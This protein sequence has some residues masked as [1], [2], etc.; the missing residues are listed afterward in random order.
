MTVDA[1]G[2]TATG[3]G[4]R[5]GVWR[6]GGEFMYQYACQCGRGTGPLRDTLF[7]LTDSPTPKWG[8]PIAQTASTAGGPSKAFAPKCIGASPG[9][10]PAPNI[11]AIWSVQRH[12][13]LWVPHP[14]LP[15][16]RADRHGLII[17]P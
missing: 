17:A 1:C 14:D 6:G 15:H 16:P 3:C 8:T 12:D 5:T 4:G 10:P 13:P 9:R 7:A 11:I 2:A